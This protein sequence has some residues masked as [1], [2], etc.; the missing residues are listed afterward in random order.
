M[1]LRQAIERAEAMLPGMAVPGHDRD[2]RWDVILEVGYF[3]QTKPE[4]VWSFVER[5]G[6]H[7]DPDLRLA[8]G[9]CILEHLLG[10]HFTMTFPRV[11]R[12]A[13]N[14]ASFADTFRH[15]RRM[16]QAEAAEPTSRWDALLA[17]IAPEPAA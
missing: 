14:S 8:I 11:E 16:G 5:W 1:T 7:Q 10:Y 13:T 12:L 6:Q 4:E 15:C 17:R 3:S 2:H 9:L